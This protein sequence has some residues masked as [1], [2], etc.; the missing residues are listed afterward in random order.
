MSAEERRQIVLA[1]ALSEFAKGGLKGTSTEVVAAR[2][3]ISQPY[4]FRLFPS[5]KALFVEVVKYGFGRVERRFREVSEGLPGP[6]VLEAM[7]NAY[8]E[9]LQDRELL[10]A[11]H[12]FYA[13][14]ADPDIRA[15]VR[16][17]FA[18]MWQMVESRSGATDAELQHFFAMGMLCNVVVAMDL[19]DLR[20]QWAQAAV[21][22]TAKHDETCPFST[23]SGL[24]AVAE[25]VASSS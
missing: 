6:E 21:P 1:A 17:C 23:T 12:Q 22:G 25:T 3:G 20:E 13:A 14:C 18:A 15:A 19:V 16:T 24:V 11:Q 2:C 10:L 9:L 5:K 7:G 4:L 8:N